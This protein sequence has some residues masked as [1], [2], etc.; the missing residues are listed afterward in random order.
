MIELP[1]KTMPRLLFLWLTDFTEGVIFKNF[2]E[3]YSLN[4][5]YH[6]LSQ[7]KGLFVYIAWQKA[8]LLMYI[9]IRKKCSK[10]ILTL[11]DTE[12]VQK[13]DH[14]LKIYLLFIIEIN[15]WL[16]INWI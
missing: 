4:V 10:N 14:T 13:T 2:Y 9:S 5:N 1:L 8:Y 7:S 11:Q 16:Y 6:I 3:K 15:N 12:Q